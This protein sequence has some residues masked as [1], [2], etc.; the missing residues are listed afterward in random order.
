[1]NVITKNQL[2]FWAQC[3]Y[4]EIAQRI[5]KYSDIQYTSLTPDK[6]LNNLLYITL[7]YVNIYGSFKL[8]KTIRYFLAHP[9]DK[10]YECSFLLHLLVSRPLERQSSQQWSCMCNTKHRTGP[11]ESSIIFY[12]HFKNQTRYSA[13][14]TRVIEMVGWQQSKCSSERPQRTW[15]D[16]TRPQMCCV[17]A[18]MHFALLITC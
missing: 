12:F 15:H 2:L 10:F 5:F 17:H 8:S 1:M 7:F 9:V 3:R 16:H 14:T 6:I 4:T 18:R 11:P 13:V